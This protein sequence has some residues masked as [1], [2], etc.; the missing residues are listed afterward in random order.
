MGVGYIGLEFRR[1]VM[2]CEED[3]GVMF[4]EMVFINRRRRRSKRNR[5][6]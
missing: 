5:S 6:S 1:K 3:V 4:T 2:V